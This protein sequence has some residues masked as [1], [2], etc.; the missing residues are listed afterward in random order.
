MSGSDLTTRAG[1]V[2]VGHDPS[3]QAF[4]LRILRMR[5]V[6]VCLFSY[7]PGSVRLLANARNWLKRVP[8]ELLYLDLKAPN[9]LSPVQIALVPVSACTKSFPFSEI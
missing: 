5:P 4:S 2:D 3:G 9:N 8:C 7:F 6:S 1:G